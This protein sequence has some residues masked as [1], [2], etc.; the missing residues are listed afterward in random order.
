M[1]SNR[2]IVLSINDLHEKW[3]SWLEDAELNV[4]GLHASAPAL[5]EFI[6]SERGK[7]WKSDLEEAGIEFEFEIHAMESLLPR[8]E[9]DHH[10]DWFRMDHHGERTPDGNLCPSNPDGMKVVCENALA[11]SGILAPTTSRFHLWQGDMRSWCHCPKCH[12]LSASDQNLMVMNSL[13]KTLRKVN[14]RAKVAYLA[15][16]NTLEA[17]RVVDPEDGVFLEFAPIERSYDHPLRDESVERNRLHVQKLYDLLELFG[18]KDAQVLEYWLDASRFSDWKRPA[19]ELKFDENIV[20]S[21]IA[22]YTDLGFEFITTFG[23]YLDE[24][25]LSSYGPPPIEQYGALLKHN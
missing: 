16:R 1:V 7:Q 5:L 4:L 21:D 10:P 22:F 12:R 2:G 14:P 23:V 8:R 15:Y 13:T 17:P 19:K 6:K 24:Y 9:F 18:K 20:A 3:L 25:Y 11:L